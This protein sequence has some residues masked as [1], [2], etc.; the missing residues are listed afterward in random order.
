[1]RVLLVEASA[2]AAATLVRVLRRGGWKV[3]AERVVRAEDVRGALARRHWDAVLVAD[4][5]PRRRR[6]A[7]LAA[8]R[9][10]DL[11]LTVIV[12]S[13]GGGTD[14]ALAALRA[15]AHDCV[16]RRELWRLV[17]VLR[18]ELAAVRERRRRARAERANRAKDAFLAMLSHELRTPQAALLACARLLR[19]HDMPEDARARTLEIMERAVRAQGD[20]VGD[21]LDV[22]R[23]AAGQLQLEPKPVRLSTIV[24]S[25]V[26]LASPEA[27]EKGVGITLHANDEGYVVA[28]SRR[29][30]QVVGNLVAN[31]VK[32]TPTGGWVLV[33]VERIGDEIVLRVTDSGSGIE[34]EFLPH[35]FDRF[36]QGR[37]GERQ[38]GLGLGLAIVRHLVRLHGGS[39][40]AEN[41][42]PG[43]GARFTVVLPA[44]PTT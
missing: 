42:A 28:D 25:A 5:L 40:R 35:I 38:G 31:G 15:G 13:D 12:V 11:G 33:E 26:A 2:D 20:L 8:V 24:A 10:H 44:L 4:S 30:Q 43:G 6:A 22:S 9:D 34:P 14:A 37:L 27:Q 19:R 29:L 18:R 16:T 7:A 36:R 3:S 17:P 1:V 23:I 32:F 21:L 41:A 39:V